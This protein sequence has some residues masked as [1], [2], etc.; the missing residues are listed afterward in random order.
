M[1]LFPLEVLADD[2]CQCLSRGLDEGRSD[3]EHVEEHEQRAELAEG[4]V[5]R[6]WLGGQGRREGFDAEGLLGV[7]GDQ[8]ADDEA[9]LRRTEPTSPARKVK[10]VTPMVASRTF[11]MVRRGCLPEAAP[12]RNASVKSTKTITR[13]KTAMSADVSNRGLAQL[14]IPTR[15]RGI[16]RGDD[17][18]CSPV[19]DRQDVVA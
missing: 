19:D 1:W 14:G 9:G 15:S 2:I 13:T 4:D 10:T 18:R 16:R 8:R 5:Q 7:S 11:D 12:I 6:N 3:A 17:V